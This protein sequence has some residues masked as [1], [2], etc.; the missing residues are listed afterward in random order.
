LYGSFG[1]DVIKCILSLTKVTETGVFVLE[2]SIPKR[3]HKL[4]MVVE[5]TSSRK[6]NR[7]IEFAV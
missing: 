2:A 4:L 6:G 5:D 3:K 7:V 1:I